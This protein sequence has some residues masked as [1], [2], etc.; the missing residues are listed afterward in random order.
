MSPQHHRNA[1]IPPGYIHFSDFDLTLSLSPS[2]F[3]KRFH[4][5]NEVSGGDKAPCLTIRRVIGI[6]ASSTDSVFVNST[7]ISGNTEAAML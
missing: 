5:E 4:I 1:D 6:L 7:N 2:S 3:A